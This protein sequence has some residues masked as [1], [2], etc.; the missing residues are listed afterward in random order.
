MSANRITGVVISD[1][2]GGHKYG[3]CNPDTILLDWDFQGNVTET[4]VSL[5]ST[6]EYLWALYLRLIERMSKIDN[7]LVLFHLGDH[8]NGKKYP[9]GLMRS[10]DYNQYNIAYMNFLP[11]LNLPNLKEIKLV[12]GTG[13]HEF[14][15]GSSVL[16]VADRLS[17]RHKDI[18]TTVCRHGAL[19]MDGVVIDYA[20]HGPGP[21]IRNWT[22]GNVAR[23]YLRSLMLD[24]IEDG[25]EPPG[26]VLRGHFHTPVEEV[27]LIRRRESR[28]V[29]MPSFCGLSDFAQQAT[30]ST[31]RIT[32]GGMFFHVDDGVIGRPEWDVE[33]MDIRT[34][35]SIEWTN[36]SDSAR[37][38]NSSET[39][40]EKPQSD[41]PVWTGS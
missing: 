11:W 36:S 12:F 22:R 19:D 14:G 21:G 33:T 16:W 10:D 25:N 39:Q 34:K 37:S 13:S 30:K 9:E 18:K 3:L 17:D 2:H 27:V 15:E 40:S 38:S 41:S 24:E 29:V 4:P 28:L 8:T 32:N 6:Q 31:Y 7:G 20:H 26:L 23:H 1:T 35:E 5:T